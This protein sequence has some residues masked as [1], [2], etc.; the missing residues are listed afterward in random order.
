V[1]EIDSKDV[2]RY[3][4]RFYAGKG[5]GGDIKWIPMG[6]V[7]FAK[8]A[9]R[10]LTKLTEESRKLAKWIERILANSIGMSAVLM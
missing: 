5:F 3:G 7:D 4:W 10:Q 9:I 6:M 8:E 1:E 2:S